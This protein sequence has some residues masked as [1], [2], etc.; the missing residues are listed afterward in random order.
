MFFDIIT[1]SPRRYS[2]NN[3]SRPSGS[4]GTSTGSTAPTP[5]AAPAN[6]GGKTP[7]SQKSVSPGILLGIS[8]GWLV[9]RMF[10]LGGSL[11]ILEIIAVIIAAGIAH[12]K[13][14]K[15]QKV[16]AKIIIILAV[17]NFFIPGFNSWVK[18]I[19]DNQLNPSPPEQSTQQEQVAP[20]P[21]EEEVD[22]RAILPVSKKYILL[23]RNGQY[24]VSPGKYKVCIS[25]LGDKTGY[26]NQ[27]VKLNNEEFI[28][29]GSSCVQK[30][31]N[32]EFINVE[33]INPPQIEVD[34]YLMM[35]NSKGGQ[36]VYPF[37]E[38]LN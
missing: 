30:E 15:G 32:T 1:M 33:F 26:Y 13:G 5:A 6:S 2:L 34:T 20:A 17:L 38:K 25:W 18:G 3:S 29:T 31:I 22:K 19:R 28:A 16:T 37:V 24:K 12:S 8:G 14:G 4:T 21:V 23:K 10:L 36:G 27:G 35:R 11:W 7:N 9:A